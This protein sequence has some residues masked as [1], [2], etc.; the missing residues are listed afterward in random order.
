MS[1][2]VNYASSRNGDDECQILEQMRKAEGCCDFIVIDSVKCNEEL[3][4]VFEKDS[5]GLF[6]LDA[7]PQSV[8]EH[9]A[10]KPKVNESQKSKVFHFFIYNLYYCFTLKTIFHLT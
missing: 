2:K 9:K 4:V 10:Q 8:D 7:T 1:S 5:S 3:K 6:F